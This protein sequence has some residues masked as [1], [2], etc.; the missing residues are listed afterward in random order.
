MHPSVRSAPANQALLQTV[1]LGIHLARME[2]RLATAH[3]F[4]AFPHAR[5]STREGMSDAD[6]EMECGFLSSVKGHRCLVEE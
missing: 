1:C 5:V 3:F 4:R 2:L 6:M